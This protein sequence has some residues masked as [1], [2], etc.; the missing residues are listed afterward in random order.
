MK[1]FI[2][3]TYFI[4]FLFSKQ[5][6]SNFVFL[7]YVYYSLIYFKSYFLYNFKAGIKHLYNMKTI[8][9]S[10]RET[11]RVSKEGKHFRQS[12]EHGVVLQKNAESKLRLKNN[13][14]V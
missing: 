13:N 4:I 6:I 14:K 1:Y 9:K 5:V 2:I 3:H 7:K 10:P 8:F 12:K 11:T